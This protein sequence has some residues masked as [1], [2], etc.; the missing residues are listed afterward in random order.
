MLGQRMLEAPLGNGNVELSQKY[1]PVP[2]KL[3]PAM[4]QVIKLKYWYLYCR[5][6]SEGF[7]HYLPA[8]T[9]ARA[10]PPFHA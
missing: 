9:R 3:W 8:S 7:S 10:L 2:R 1:S 5:A 4:D 6:S